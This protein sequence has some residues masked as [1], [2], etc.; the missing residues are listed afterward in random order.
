MPTHTPSSS[1]ESIVI[2]P[3]LTA[4]A[5]DALYR[6][7][8]FRLL[9]VTIDVTSD[10]LKRYAHQLAIA[11]TSG[12]PAQ[13]Q[14]GI[15][16]LPA[17]VATPQAQQDALQRMQ[18]P[19][20]R[21]IDEF[22]WFWPPAAAQPDDPY[23]ALLRQD[24]EAA[25]AGWHAVIQR[26]SAD[27]IA[28]H[29]LAVLAHLLALDYEWQLRSE[30]LTKQLQTQRMAYWN[31]AYNCWSLCLR[32]ETVWQWMAQRGMEAYMVGVSSIFQSELR[33]AIPIIL[34]RINA[35]LAYR[36]AQQR[37]NT[38]VYQH[39]HLIRTC[40]WPQDTIA[41]VLLQTIQP[42][43]RQI[44]SCCAAAQEQLAQQ[45]DRCQIIIRRLVTD[46]AAPL[47]VIDNLLPIR[48]PLAVT[49]HDQVAR[50][51]ADHAVEDAMRQQRWE[52]AI[53]LLEEARGIARGDSLHISLQ[54]LEET[55]K[56]NKDFTMCWFCRTNPADEQ[57][58]ADI[59]LYRPVVDESDA[60]VGGE[61]DSLHYGVPRCA[62]C[63]FLHHRI[64]HW[65]L[66]GYPF[67]L[68]ASI[69]GGWVTAAQ[70]ASWWGWLIAAGVIML[71]Y[72][73][74]SLLVETGGRFRAGNKFKEESGKYIFPP[75]R[76]I[77]D[78][79]WRVG[80]SPPGQQ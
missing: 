47:A 16:P 70:L 2:P 74:G 31:L 63:F 55:L 5:H 19:V 53:A 7:N 54:Q 56:G 58:V 41:T 80:A 25:V 60:P 23:H 24:Y 42:A 27:F 35:G 39:L 52:D 40:D 12:I 68:L 11:Q 13:Q 33:A 62:R 10:Y 71:V 32:Q 57:T 48:H 6:Q 75:L 30:G 43:Q 34:L 67:V 49:L 66:Y 22:F 29:N 1:S 65:R 69:G 72:G 17:A 38:L 61:W 78:A 20:K 3:E 8:V 9:G 59:E 36:A 45:P 4:V 37:E 76:K 44:E 14:P 73:L 28:A 64:T 15:F 21:F 77:L 50:M 79:G 26:N 46:S 51:I 18:D